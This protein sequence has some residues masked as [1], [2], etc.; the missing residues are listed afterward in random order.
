[1]YVGSIQRVDHALVC[2]K[3]GNEM[4]KAERNYG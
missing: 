1:M 2:Y 4:T 3:V